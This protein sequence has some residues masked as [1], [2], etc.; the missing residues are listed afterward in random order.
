[1]EEQEGGNLEFSLEGSGSDRG[2]KRIETRISRGFS[3]EIL[4]KL[5]EL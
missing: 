3:N 1:M 4:N 5:R 2:S